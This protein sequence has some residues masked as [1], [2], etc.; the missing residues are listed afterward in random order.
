[1]NFDEAAKYLKMSADQGNADAQY[2][3]VGEGVWIDPVEAEKYFK[4]S[5]DQGNALAKAKLS[6]P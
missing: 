1:M 5:A 4:M 3:Y 2:S 6:N